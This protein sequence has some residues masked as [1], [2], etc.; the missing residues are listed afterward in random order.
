M[1]KFILFLFIWLSDSD[2]RVQESG[3]F[4]DH[5]ECLKAGQAYM[6]D[7]AINRFLCVPWS[8]VYG[9]SI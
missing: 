3:V 6:H 9:G 8:E 2:Q 4:P 5:G 7:P 1:S